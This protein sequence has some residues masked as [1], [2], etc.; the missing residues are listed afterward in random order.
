MMAICS[1]PA[2]FLR[3]RL[4]NLRISVSTVHT[5]EVVDSLRAKTDADSAIGEWPQFIWLI[6]QVDPPPVP[7]QEAH[8]PAILKLRHRPTSVQDVPTCEPLARTNHEPKAHL[9]M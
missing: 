4:L 2:S 3:S 1:M 6:N 5:V 7:L 8:R 9:C